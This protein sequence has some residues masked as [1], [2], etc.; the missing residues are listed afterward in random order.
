M[1][2]KKIKIE[3][4]YIGFRNNR[5]NYRCKECG[6]GYN[7]LINEAVKNFPATY[8]FCNGNL[9]KFIL[10]LRKGVYPYKY[11]HSW[12]KF[13]ETSIPPEEAYY[14]Q[15]NEEGISDSDYVNVQKVWGVFEIKDMG[16]N[17]DLC[18]QIHTLLLADVFE[19]F[20]DKYIEIY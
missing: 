20:R 16:E 6:K 15:L 3:C 1:E 10:L 18:V 5:L 19:N 4:D 8:Q 11:M 9:N 14:S 2:R 7:K 12:E 13:D 17:H